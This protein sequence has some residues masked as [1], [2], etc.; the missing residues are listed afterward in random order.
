MTR[1]LAL[2][3]IALLV[4]TASCEPV[5]MVE[6]REYK[7]LPPEVVDA[8]IENDH[9]IVNGSTTT[10]W[11]SVVFLYM[12]GYICTGTL[13][14]PDVVL[15]AAH[16]IEG[17]YGQIDVYW[18]NNIDQGY[19]Y[20][21]T[22]NNYVEYPG[23]SYQQ[24]TGD[25]AVVV[26]SQ[27][28]PTTPI[29]INRDDPSNS[30]LGNS[31]P[32]WFVGFGVTNPNWEDSG[33]KRE[34][35][36]AIDGWDGNGLYHEDYNH[37]TCFGD[38]GGPSLTDHSGSWRVASVVS[39]G[40]QDCAYYGYNTRADAYEQW[41]DQHTGNWTPDDDD[42]SD[43][44]DD[45]SD[46]DDDVSDDDDDIS[47]DDGGDD[48]TSPPEPIEELP[49]PRTNANYDRAQGCTCIGDI[50]DTGAAAPLGLAGLL[51]GVALVMLRRR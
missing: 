21:R 28:G 25:I 40:D 41:I 26:L 38:S 13:I 7:P 4:A 50:A 24:N 34:V 47:D 3:C 9:G 20:H 6:D 12:G 17:I 18:C 8:L 2:L 16:C 27:D 51:C 49:G 1:R 48:D 39:N 30:W 32:L 19:Y 45:V 10:D 37:N 46:D 29:P 42:V 11:D 36:I 31:N 43:D 15:T 5:M 22:S 35:Q 44:D 14:S 23:Y 33:I